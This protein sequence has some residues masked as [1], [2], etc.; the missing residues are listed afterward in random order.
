MAAPTRANDDGLSGTTT[1]APASI[2]R[3]VAILSAPSRSSRSSSSA[4]ALL[5]G[6]EGPPARSLVAAPPLYMGAPRVSVTSRSGM[7]RRAKWSSAIESVARKNRP[8]VPPAVAAAAV[9][10]AET[11]RCVSVPLP[12]HTNGRGRLSS[13]CVL[14]ARAARSVAVAQAAAQSGGVARDTSA[15]KPATRAASLRLVSR[16]S[17]H[18]EAG[19]ASKATRSPSSRRPSLSKPSRPKRAWIA[20][21]CGGSCAR[22][23]LTRSSSAAV[24]HTSRRQRQR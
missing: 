3:S 16:A 24:G 9:P 10:A 17:R 14:V 13:S 20:A 11:S 18:D 23:A 7:K 6:L 5:L 1:R 2:S 8:A 12:Q 22:S 19:A 21:Y 15:S 4:D